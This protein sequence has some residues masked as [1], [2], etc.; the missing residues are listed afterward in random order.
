MLYNPDWK[1]ITK[2]FT[3]PDFIAW[4]ETKPSS[5]VYDFDN[6]QGECLMGQYMAARGRKWGYGPVGHGV[7]HSAYWQSCL[8]VFDGGITGG[9]I[10]LASGP[11]TFGGALERAR[12]LL[13]P[14]VT[15]HE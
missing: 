15:E 12:K 2:P 10:V 5:E 7:T 13:S 4:L 11:K 1:V 9:S 14:Q 6:C 8:D 3:L